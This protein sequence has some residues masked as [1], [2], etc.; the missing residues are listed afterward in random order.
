M[1]SSPLPFY[2]LNA[3][4]PTLHSG[5]QAAVVFFDSASHPQSTDEQFMTLVARDFN[6]AETAYLVSLDGNR[7]SKVGKYGLRWFTPEEE[8][9][10]CG[11]ATLA[12]SQAVFSINP[13]FE[14]IEFTTRFSGVLTA[15]KV[16]DKQVEITLPSLPK[17]VLEAFG[18]K[19]SKE[20]LTKVGSVFGVKEEE[21]VAVSPFAFGTRSS[22]IV[23][24]SPQVDLAKIKASEADLLAFSDGM[25]IVTQVAREQPDDQLHINSRVFAPGLGITEDPV[26]GSAH[27][28]LTG[29]YVN[30]PL[31]T[32]LLPK[33][34][35]G[36]LLT[37][38]LN[39]TQLSKR[40]GRLICIW[41]DGKVK[42]VGKA[43]EFG[44]G[45]LSTPQA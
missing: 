29:Y 31:T 1:P 34:F 19:S 20:D 43:W 2:L 32:E 25:I 12:A 16:E 27:A 40:G 33:K 37:T 30:S 44:R 23:S 39:G 24:L 28:Y 21:I 7:E 38:V 5:N 11:H 18:G 3:F 26:T 45:T 4:A 14:T 10:L 22:V 35:A 36:S 8:V 41:D 42:L 9:A 17:N 13:A 15:K 6:F